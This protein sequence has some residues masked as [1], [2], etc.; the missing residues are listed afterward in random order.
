VVHAR[1]RDAGEGTLEIA[2]VVLRDDEHADEVVLVA[3]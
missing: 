1:D 3:Q 2:L